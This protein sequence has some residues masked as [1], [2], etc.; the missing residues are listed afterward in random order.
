M[1]VWLI[2]GVSV[3]LQH[4]VSEVSFETGGR[5]SVT[6]HDD[7]AEDFD[8]VI[9][10]LPAPQILDLRGSLHESIGEELLRLAFMTVLSHLS[11]SELI[12]VL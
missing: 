8:V 5:V 10:T 12:H 9:F 7:I 6:T 11:T 1:N 4:E 3:K 2:S